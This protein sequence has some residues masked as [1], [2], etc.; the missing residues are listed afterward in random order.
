MY[1]YL[2]IEFDF[3][4]ATASAGNRLSFFANRM[5]RWKVIGE[6]NIYLELFLLLFFTYHTKIRP[7]IVL[8]IFRAYNN[9]LDIV[10]IWYT[11]GE[12]VW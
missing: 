5:D 2:Y 6:T 7:I 11:S 3:R 12:I 8:Y 9:I 4:K 10:L 1:N